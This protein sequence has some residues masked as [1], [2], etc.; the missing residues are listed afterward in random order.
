MEAG[1]RVFRGIPFA[2][3]PLRELR[4]KPPQAVTSWTGTRD[5]S[6]Y[7]PACTQPSVKAMTSEDCLYLNVYAPP[8]G[9]NDGQ[10]LPCLLWVHGGAYVSGS[11]SA[12]NATDLV[13]FFKS[14]QQPAI[15]ITTN[16]RLGI[17][18]FFGAEGLRHRDSSGSTGNYGLQDQRAAFQWVR[19]NIPAF[20]GNPER[21]MIFGESAG[22][23]SMTAHLVMPRSWGLFSSI[24]LESGSFPLWSA[25]PMNISEAIYQKM[26]SNTSCADA[27]CLE[28]LS[29][30]RLLFAQL[31]IPSTFYDKLWCSF[32]P[33]VD[34]VELSG[35]PWELA[36]QGKFAKVPVLHGAN[37]D[38][39]TMFTKLA[40]TA[41]KEQLFQ[42]IQ[43]RVGYSE[44]LPKARV[45]N[46]TMDYL[47]TE[48]HPNVTLITHEYWVAERIIGDVNFLCP[49]KLVSPLLSAGGE[50]VYE[51]FYE[52]VNS[53]QPV[54]FV[55]HGAEVQFVLGW[56]EHM[57]Q[58]ERE[59]SQQMASY[60][61]RHAAFGNPNGIGR[62]G[63][64][65]KWPASSVGHLQLDVASKGG[66]TQVEGPWRTWQCK[67]VHDLMISVLSEHKP[68]EIIV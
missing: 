10:G 64:F 28:G 43:N 22:A 45:E 46:T 34:G 63:E 19:D 55:N 58:E 67:F 32:S 26:L 41:G 8:R 5:A 33:T 6:K 54:P 49:T 47:R 48:K 3:P 9:S 53:H 52:H 61:Y 21:V 56:T 12:Y 18:G 65:V 59:L 50:G 2:A 14:S 38:E 44:Y 23:G 39:G 27:A 29:A 57:N 20:G 31:S 68:L 37:T 36:Q 24:A 25:K 51:Y 11:A 30:A 60:W 62:D 4:W 35:H 17:L 42:F 15:V 16:Y 66:V 40:R 1:V 13:S 7:G